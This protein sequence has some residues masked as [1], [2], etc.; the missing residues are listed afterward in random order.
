MSAGERPAEAAQ[1]GPWLSQVEPCRRV[2]SADEIAWDAS[3]DF[4]VVGSGAAGSSAAAEACEQGLAVT[5]IDRFA[6]GGTTVASGGVIYAGG[7]TSIQRA[8]GVQDSPEE[9]FRYLRL[10]TQGCVSDP[11]LRRF[12]EQSRHTLDW[13]IAKGVEFRATLYPGK[14]SYP[15]VDYFLY[16]PD[17]SL[18]GSY[19]AQAQPAARGHRGAGRLT[20]RQMEAAV[21]LGG[22]LIWPLHDW[23]RA[24][25]VR[26]MPFTEAR[27]L[28]QD[29]DGRVLGARVLELPDGPSRT[30][31]THHLQTGARLQAL[32]PPIV[33]GSRLLRRLARRHLREAERLEREAR[34]A[35]FIR[36]ERG[37]CL[38]AGGFICN[39]PMVAHYAPS[40]RAGFP[41]GTSGDDGSGIRLG[42]SAGG[43][44]G[45]MQRMTAW[46]FIN[47]PLAW[48]RGIVVNRRGERVCN[49]TVYGATLGIELVEQHGG[50][51]WLI[52]DARLVREARAQIAPGRTLPFQRQ[53]ARLNMLIGRQRAR[54]L[55]QLAARTGIDPEGL[56]RSIAAYN[57]AARGEIRDPLGKDPEDCAGITA[58]PFIAIDVG[59]AAKWFPCPTL[60]LGGLV[61]DEDSGLVRSE[62]GEPIPGLYAAGRSAV[63][64]SSHLYVSG[65]SIADGVFSGRRA[66]LH[67]AS[68]RTW[69]PPP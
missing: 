3:T 35:R 6:G 61:V 34:V 66:G 44:T 49:E 48:A 56:V 37:V 4:L 9:M 58:P 36:A 47:P 10:E 18:V 57:R 33:P 25:G 28:V 46:R 1:S 27:Q 2:A 41:L 63:G 20:R 31:F 69:E 15:P 21:G 23:C 17:N 62:F 13:L 24:R 45:R 43:A 55:R 54:T 14:T 16:H 67:A 40:Y 19:A 26:W 60:T 7:G 51:G 50:E 12:C 11:T 53:L 59:I 52:L 30:S 8:A 38:A 42:Q 64:V 65:L 68:G 29:R 5:M 22:S 32:L 39:R